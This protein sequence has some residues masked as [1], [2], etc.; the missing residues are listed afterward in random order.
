MLRR[1]YKRFLADVELDCGEVITVFC[2]NTGRMTGCAEPGSRVWLSHHR[3]PHRKYAYTWELVEV[4]GVMVGVNTHLPNAL[5]REAIESNRIHTLS[6]YDVIQ[7]EVRYGNERSRI[8]LMLRGASRRDCYV[9]VKNVN[10]EVHAGVGHFPDA[11]SARAA[12]H[13]REL[14]GVRE[15]GNR[16][17]VVFLV[18]RADVHT[19]APADHIDAAYGNAFR[20]ALDDGVEVIALS[21]YVTAER[22]TVGD[23]VDVR[24][25]G[26][27]VGA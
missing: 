16:A 14:A 9:E 1:R 12:K 2:P 17:V 4:D 24:R 7:S 13:M 22:I 21:T 8:D 19:V 5:V 23:A 26:V 18:Q 25:H 20:Q 10:S 6:G 15:Q 3:S 27:R 11:V